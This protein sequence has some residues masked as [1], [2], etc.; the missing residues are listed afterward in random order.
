MKLCTKSADS[1]KKILGVEETA[2]AEHRKELRFEIVERSALVH[3]NDTNTNWT[4]KTSKK[5]HKPNKVF[6]F[7]FTV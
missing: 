3:F 1:K 4:L 2:S 7:F 5:K 6:T